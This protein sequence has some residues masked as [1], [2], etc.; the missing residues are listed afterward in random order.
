MLW[1]VVLCLWM[2]ERIV[3]VDFGLR[4][5]STLMVSIYKWSLFTRNGIA[6]PPTLWQ[7]ACLTKSWL[8][9]DLFD[10]P[11]FWAWDICRRPADR[12]ECPCAAEERSWNSFPKSWI[13]KDAFSFVFFLGLGYLKR[14][15]CQVPS[16]H[17]FPTQSQISGFGTSTRL[18][19]YHE[20]E[21]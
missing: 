4:G 20:P 11:E 16:K 14:C 7:A 8:S 6:A 12:E 19:Y 2:L 13:S 17:I 21:G 9:G 5:T 18:Y 1:V 3:F 10:R 15:Q